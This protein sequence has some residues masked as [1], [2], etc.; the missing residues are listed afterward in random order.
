MKILLLLLVGLLSA[1]DPISI[2]NANIQDTIAMDG[3][4][5]AE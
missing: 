5:L 4:L 3:P 1:Q 2:N